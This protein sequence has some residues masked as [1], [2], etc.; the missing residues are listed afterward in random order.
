[1]RL[2]DLNVDEATVGEHRQPAFARK[3]AGDSSSPKID[4]THRALGHRLA[5]GDIAEL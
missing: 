3:A 4:L 1:M 2:A 5:V